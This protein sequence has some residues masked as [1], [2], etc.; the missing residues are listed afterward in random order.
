MT[1]ATETQA[2]NTPELNLQLR[3]EF[4]S[5]KVEKLKI[6]HNRQSPTREFSQGWQELLSL[7]GRLCDILLQACCY[8]SGAGFATS[9]L[10]ALPPLPLII[11]PAAVALVA[12]LSVAAVAAHRYPALRCA[13]LYRSILVVMGVALG[14]WL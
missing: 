7:P 1:Q 11:V 4:G 6:D 2:P 14:V 8:V 5:Q 9:L 13:L 3:G 10:I 12:T